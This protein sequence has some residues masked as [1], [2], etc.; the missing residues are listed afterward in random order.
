MYFHWECNEAFSLH[1]LYFSFVKV[2]LSITSEFGEILS[3]GDVLIDSSGNSSA[4]AS[5]NVLGSSYT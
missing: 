4:S 1:I 2:S 5:K 3:D